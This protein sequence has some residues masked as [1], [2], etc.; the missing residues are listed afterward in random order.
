[1][2]SQFIFAAL[3]YNLSFI[4]ICLFSG[5]E[6]LQTMKGADGEEHSKGANWCNICCIEK[7]PRAGHCTVCDVCI[8]NRD[9]HCVWWVE[10]HIA[11]TNHVFDYIVVWQLT[12]R[13]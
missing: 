12:T 6:D 13:M 5:M 8:Y 10:W 7:P 3:I 9:H 4:N 11:S 1:V 2:N